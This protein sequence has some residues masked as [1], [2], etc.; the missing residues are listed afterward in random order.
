MCC[1]FDSV[2]ACL[3]KQF[4]ICLSVV[5]ILLLNVMEVFR[6]DRRWL[7]NLDKKIAQQEN[8]EII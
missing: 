4:S 7:L 8:R 6:N 2:C 3:M 5:V 1:V